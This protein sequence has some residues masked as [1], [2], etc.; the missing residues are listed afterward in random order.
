MHHLSPSFRKK[1]SEIERAIQAQ[2]R[3]YLINSVW[4]NNLGLDRE[5]VKQIDGIVVREEASRVA[6][7]DE[8]KV[9]SIVRLDLSY[10]AEIDT[11]K[12]HDYEGAEVMTDFYVPEAKCF[13]KINGG[14]LS[15]RAYFDLK[16]QTWSQSVHSLKT[17]SM[18]ITGRHHA[19]FAACKAEIPFVAVSGNTH[20]IEGFARMS[21]I[22]LPILGSMHG[23]SDAIKWTKQNSNAYADFFDWM[24]SQR[25]FALKDIDL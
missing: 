25:K 1:F 15:R 6:L 7:R 12:H 19:V 18:L 11:S 2:K 17:A 9:D 24:R 4:Q 20:K 21:G 23:I 5:L 10:S 8:Y 3:V 16:T 14:P 22:D 13:M